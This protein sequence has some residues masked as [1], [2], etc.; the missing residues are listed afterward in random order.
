MD[1]AALQRRLD[2][3]K[4]QLPRAGR[5][6]LIVL[7]I[8]VAIVVI[9]RVILDPLA[10]HFTR[11]ALDGLDGFRGDFARVHVTIFGPG[12]TI[13]RVKLIE[14]PGGSAREPLF[15]A[16][17]V[18]AGIDWRPLLHGRLVARLRIDEPKIN[19]IKPE[20]EAKKTAAKAPDLSAQ[21]EKA[22]GMKVDRVEVLR[23]EVLFRDLSQPAHPEM[24]LHR[25]DAAAENLATRAELAH[26]RP[27]TVS[28]HGTL[29]RSG[30]VSLFVTADPLASPLS[31]AGRFAL[32]H[33]KLAELYDFIAPKTKMQTP[34]GT[35]DV[36]A[37]FVSRKGA[38]TGGV[39][40][41]LKNVKVRPTDSG[42]WDRLKAWLADKS[43]DL[44]S[45]RVPGRN[46]VATVVPIKGTLTNPDVQL[47]PAVLG[48]VRNSFVEGLASGFTHVPPDTADSKE[49]PLTQA[50][51]ALE[52]D[53]GPPKAQPQPAQGREAAGKKR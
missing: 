53:K 27:T 44:F 21:L 11:K 2:H 29:G 25:L 5:R 20:H 33:L 16:E 12:Y 43:L 26:G 22:L 28:A 41:V 35:V 50:K 49:G 40:P 6:L 37:E 23:G 32:E 51:H 18:H 36:F 39:K 19:V 7:I 46:A 24:W 4:A 38:I 17:R 10:T 13:T 14:D 31:F 48:V 3:T 47:W 42:I 8:L 52:K 1:A 34:E 9:I 45:D 15:Y 30:D